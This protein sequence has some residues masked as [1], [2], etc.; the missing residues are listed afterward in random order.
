MVPPLDRALPKVEALAPVALRQV[1]A[2]WEDH[3]DMIVAVD[4]NGT[5]RER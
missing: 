5:W 2:I 4:A 1:V 3:F